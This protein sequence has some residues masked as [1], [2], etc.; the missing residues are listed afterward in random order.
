[1]SDLIIR[2]RITG[3]ATETSESDENILIDIKHEN[4]RH[5]V[6][7][8][9]LHALRLSEASITESHHFNASDRVMA[10]GYQSWTET[11]EFLRGERLN[12]LRRVPDFINN[13]YHFTSY[14]S[15]A[16]WPMD[17]RIGFDYSYVTG[18]D[19]LII[20][21]LHYNNEYL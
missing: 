13:R 17:G 11:K 6:T 14:G 3:V 12:D 18:D 16:F 1:M 4:G 21:S 19:P 8:K 20:G 7:V 5:T 15:Q 10:N 9:A 2:Y